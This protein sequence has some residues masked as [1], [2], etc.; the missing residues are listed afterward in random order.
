M[1]NAASPTKNA[2]CEQ[3]PKK[4]TRCLDFMKN[5]VKSKLLTGP[6]L[7]GQN[8]MTP[9]RHYVSHYVVMIF[10]FH[11]KEKRHSHSQSHNH[12]HKKMV[13]H[14]LMIMIMLIIRAPM[15]MFLDVPT[16]T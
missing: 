4:D 11:S 10:A 2:S 13:D 1:K 14:F 6:Y 12:N 3:D 5:G 9:L 8:T 7:I 16:K 15:I